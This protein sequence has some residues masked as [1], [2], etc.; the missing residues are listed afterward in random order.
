M[1]L[2]PIAGFCGAGKSLATLR[3]ALQMQQNG[4]S[5]CICLD[6][7][8]PITRALVEEYKIKAFTGKPE[9]IQGYENVICECY[10]LDTGNKA[11]LMATGCQVAPMTVVVDPARLH[12]MA[13]YGA[14][15]LNSRAYND[16]IA[17]QLKEADI[18][19]LSHA[20]LDPASDAVKAMITAVAP[21]AKQIAFSAKNG[22]GYDE[23]AEA[24]KGEAAP[25]PEI[26]PVEAEIARYDCSLHIAAPQGIFPDKFLNKLAHK[27]REALSS[28]PVP[29][30]SFQC[31]TISEEGLAIVGCTDLNGVIREDRLVNLCS[32]AC[33]L[34]IQLAGNC[35]REFL[36]D[37]MY[38]AIQHSATAMEQGITVVGKFPSVWDDE[39]EN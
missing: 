31:C 22:Q 12:M 27:T 14:M 4:E 16:I 25:A 36:C 39:D 9:E 29:L 15:T 35:D 33:E 38:D 5:V 3:L 30:A 8:N 11:K 21:N 18:V 37:V 17:A 19:L 10:G 34:H 32:I 7:E 2:I 23:W 26:A 13:A 24:L 1:R 20:D 28:L 6:R